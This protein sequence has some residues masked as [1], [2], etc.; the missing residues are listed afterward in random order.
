[1]RVEWWI[2]RTG[3]NVRLD[4]ARRKV[5]FLARRTVKK[6]VAFKSGGK[7]VSFI[8]KVPAKRRT[9]VKFYAKKK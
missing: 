5:T 9:R 8:A 3:Q 1:M 6:R 4:M 2:P 7:R